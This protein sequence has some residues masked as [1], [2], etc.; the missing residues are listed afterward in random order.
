MK[1]PQKA[2]NVKHKTIRFVEPAKSGSVQKRPA[3]ILL[4]LPTGIPGATDAAT[5]WINFANRYKFSRFSIPGTSLFRKISCTSTRFLFHP[6]P[7]PTIFVPY[8]LSL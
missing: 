5:P 8:D 4:A 6:S 1:E 7:C 2:V 3:L